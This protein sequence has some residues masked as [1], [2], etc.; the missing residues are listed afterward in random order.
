MF[1]EKP[2][3]TWQFRAEERAVPVVIGAPVTTTSSIT[4]LVSCAILDS[5][6]YPEM[7]GS[8]HFVH[9]RTD[10]FTFFTVN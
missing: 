10:A 5:E 7:G 8:L 6:A 2:K 1:Y 3:L 4:G 9:C